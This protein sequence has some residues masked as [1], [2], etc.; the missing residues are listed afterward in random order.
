MCGFSFNDIVL[1]DGKQFTIAE[2]MPNFRFSTYPPGVCDYEY[3]NLSEN[4]VTTFHGALPGE[5]CL[6]SFM[7]IHDCAKGLCAR[8][9]YY[10]AVHLYS[11][12]ST[13]TL[14]EQANFRKKR[15][16][17]L[18]DEIISLQEPK[19]IIKHSDVINLEKAKQ[20]IQTFNIRV[21]S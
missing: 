1:V 17:Q 11:D 15:I 3:E 2:L 16:A 8:P 14:S 21:Q 6:F 5:D 20:M 4:T 13:S 18:L 10:E 7:I 12:Y 19:P 9:G